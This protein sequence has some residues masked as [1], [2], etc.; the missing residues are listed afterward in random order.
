[1]SGFVSAFVTWFNGINSATCA[2]NKIH[3]DDS[4]TA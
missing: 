3:I 2:I 4:K 1:M